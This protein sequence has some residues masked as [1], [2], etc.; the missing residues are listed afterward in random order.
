MRENWRNCHSCGERA[1]GQVALKLIG[2]GGASGPVDMPP[3][4]AVVE[5]DTWL[6]AMSGVNHERT[7][8]RE[9]GL[10][11]RLGT[12]V[13][14]A[15]DVDRAVLFWS[16]VL[17]YKPVHFPDDANS[18]TILVPP[19]GEG[20]RVALQRAET[21]VQEHPRVHLDLIVDSA[22]EQEAEISRLV[23]LGAT[24]VSWDLYPP[25]P[26]FVVLAD[27]EGN[28]FCIVDASHG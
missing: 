24:Q 16:E 27:R 15:D 28:R 6:A 22:A 19:S 9:A 3:N 25:D 18:F 4:R 21:A 2:G 12:V 10:M 17:G 13:L 1:R 5:V 11:L 23:G 8:L 14:G 7:S 20:T 26:D